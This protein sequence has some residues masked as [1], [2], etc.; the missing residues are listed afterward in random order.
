MGWQLACRPLVG[1]SAAHALPPPC[2][3]HAPPSPCPA[4]LARLCPERAAV[5]AAKDDQYGG[6]IV[7]AD[8][9]PAEQSAFEAALGES[10]QVRAPRGH[11]AHGSAAT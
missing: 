2:N 9:L 8:T 5:L 7:E 1:R 6:V 11:L 3:M 4:P 10:L